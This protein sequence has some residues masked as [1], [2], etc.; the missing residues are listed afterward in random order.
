VDKV[1]FDIDEIQRVIPPD[2]G[3]TP[4]A[5]HG[6]N[7]FDADHDDKLKRESQPAMAKIA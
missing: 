2:R 1:A 6:A 3:F 5:A 4:D 7:G